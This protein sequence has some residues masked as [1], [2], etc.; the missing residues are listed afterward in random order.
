M[1]NS[2]E[3]AIIRKLQ[4]ELPLVPQ[5]YKFIAAELGISEEELL[6]KIKKLRDR[7]MLRRIGAILHHRTV[8]FKANAMVVWS[9]PIDRI[10][11]VANIMISFPEVSHCYERKTMSNWPYNIYTMIHSKS[12]DK[13]EDL[14]LHIAQTSGVDKYEVLHSTRELKKSSMKYF[15]D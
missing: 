6:N 8:G 3:R 4:E 5:P 7:K 11:D 14:I 2:L 12:F 15:I 13:C 9:V 10:R 1:E